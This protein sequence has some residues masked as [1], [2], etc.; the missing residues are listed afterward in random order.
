MLGLSPDPEKYLHAASLMWCAG[1]WLILALCGFWLQVSNA[2]VYVTDEPE[3]PP[4][5]VWG[6]V[7]GFM[8]WPTRAEWS[9]W[10]SRR[11]IWRT[12]VRVLAAGWVPVLWRD[13]LLA[14][15]LSSLVKPLVDINHSVCFSITETF[16]EEGQRLESLTQNVPIDECGCLPGFGYDHISQSCLEDHPK[17]NESEVYLWC[18]E[19]NGGD[20]DLC[21]AYFT[22]DAV[23]TFLPYYFRFSQQVR[24]Y[25]DSGFTSKRDL[26]N[27]G[28]YSTSLAVVTLSWLDHTYTKLWTDGKHVDKWDVLRIAT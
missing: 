10:T 5:V 27:A 21:N 4:I 9:L 16:F 24:R 3:S 28:K 19:D 20:V 17:L 7:M 26:V 11:R 6:I 1:I 14:N 12:F 22:L 23:V 25:I 2:W 8:F 15:I 18:N 13:V